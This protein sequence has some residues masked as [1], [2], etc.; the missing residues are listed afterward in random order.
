MFDLVSLDQ[1]MR[2]PSEL[3]S[4][5]SPLLLAEELR[6]ATSGPGTSLLGPLNGDG[7]VE[8]HCLQ[9]CNLESPA[10]VPMTVMLASSNLLMPL[11]HVQGL[12][13]AHQSVT[14]SK[15][16]RSSEVPGNEKGG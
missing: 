12:D 16:L 8:D 13:F 1:E 14:A 15:N 6:R 2:G 7:G 3:S 5:L 11:R 9:C 4:T 10:D